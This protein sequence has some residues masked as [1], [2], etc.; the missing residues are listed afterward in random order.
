VFLT[1]GKVAVSRSVP[2]D[3]GHNEYTFIHG[4]CYQKHFKLDGHVQLDAANTF[5][6]GNDRARGLCIIESLY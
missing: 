5:F 2:I 6:L 1:L 4:G 3:Y